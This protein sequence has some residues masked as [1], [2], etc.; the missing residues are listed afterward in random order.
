MLMV[1]ERHFEAIKI[2]HEAG[3][4]IAL[5]TDIFA[6]GPAAGIAWGMN[7]Q[8]FVHLVDAGL[9]PLEAIE[10]GTAN[11]PPTLGPQAPRSGLLAE[12]YDAMSSQSWANPLEDI[13][14]LAEPANVTHIWKA[15]ELGAQVAAGGMNTQSPLAA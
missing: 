6:S 9:S 12:G 3:V 8:E 2:A 15:G 7:G 10:A 1:A 13:S 14:V 11:G 5:G 4:K